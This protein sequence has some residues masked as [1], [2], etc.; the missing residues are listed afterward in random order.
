MAAARPVTLLC[1]W[2]NSAP[3]NAATRAVTPTPE[4]SHSLFW[5]SHFHITGLFYPS[6][7]YWGHC[8]RVKCED[9]RWCYARIAADVVLD[10]SQ[11]R[12]KMKENEDDGLLGVTEIGA[13]PRPLTPNTDHLRG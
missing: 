4:K 11:P 6:G 8:T 2:R 1:G 9:E 3:Q 5:A 7:P 12:K 13:R 10:K